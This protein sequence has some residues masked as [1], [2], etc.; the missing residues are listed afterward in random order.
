MHFTELHAIALGLEISQNLLK[1][2]KAIAQYPCA[3]SAIFAW[4]SAWILRIRALNSV[5]AAQS[6]PWVIRGGNPTAGGAA[7]DAAPPGFP[8]SRE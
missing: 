3:F 7:G 8:L 4:K 6:V 5:V 2:R 1:L